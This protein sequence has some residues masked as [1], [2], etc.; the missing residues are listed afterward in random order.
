MVAGNIKELKQS[1]HL[2]AEYVS[3]GTKTQVRRHTQHCSPMAQQIN[4][5]TFLDLGPTFS[6]LCAIFLS[7]MTTL[8][9][10]LLK[11]NWDSSSCPQW[12]DEAR[13]SCFYFRSGLAEFRRILLSV[14]Q[15]LQNS[16]EMLEEHYFL[17]DVVIFYFMCLAVSPAYMYVC[18]VCLMLVEAKRRC[19][20][21]WNQ[22]YRCLWGTMWVLWTL[23]HLSSISSNIIITHITNW[24]L[25]F[26]IP[27]PLDYFPF[28]VLRQ[29]LTVHI[30]LIKIPL[31]LPPECCD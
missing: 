19:H 10:S 5:N 18:Y 26:I 8:T 17:K 22:S 15:S 11:L 31:T 12:I 23:L 29:A 3:P 30:Q 7:V 2:V 27:L 25:F 14:M 9:S 1:S 28:E 13:S 6:R 21:P 20:I 24:L 4:T 16:R